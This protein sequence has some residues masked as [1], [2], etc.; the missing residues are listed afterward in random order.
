MIGELSVLADR[1]FII[2]NFQKLSFRLQFEV[3]E[4]I[5]EQERKF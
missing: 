5:K 1:V 3:H 2:A 4:F